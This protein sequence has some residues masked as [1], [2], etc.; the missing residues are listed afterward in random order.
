MNYFTYEVVT[1]EAIE[2]L[3]KPGGFGKC[4]LYNVAIDLVREAFTGIRLQDGVLTW[5]D[6]HALCTGFR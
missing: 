1:A 3:E 5:V 2:T 4:L 6:E